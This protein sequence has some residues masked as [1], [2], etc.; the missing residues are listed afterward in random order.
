MAKKRIATTDDLPISQP[1]IDTK[2]ETIPWDPAG[3]DT[4]PEAPAAH[5]NAHV[6]D[7]HTQQQ[8]NEPAS[9]PDDESTELEEFITAVRAV[10]D[11]DTEVQ[12]PQNWSRS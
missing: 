7:L 4:P 1:P 8:I 6:L 10:A 2:P 3:T 11:K 5:H 12:T 9:A